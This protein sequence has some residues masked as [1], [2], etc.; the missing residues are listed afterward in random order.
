MHGS[1]HVHIADSVRAK[2]A[3][4][5]TARFADL[6]PFCPVIQALPRIPVGRLF[7]VLLAP[8]GGPCSYRPPGRLPDRPAPSHRGSTERMTG[9]ASPPPG[10]KTS[11]AP[12]RSTLCPDLD[13]AARRGVMQQGFPVSPVRDWIR[14]S[15]SCTCRG[16]VMDL[17][18]TCRIPAPVTRR[19][20]RLRCPL[21]A[22]ASQV[23]SRL[24]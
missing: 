14:R 15:R 3:V 16:L 21:V 9:C 22:A 8:G 19:I 10:W 24:T 17:S 11:T 4:R 2:L 12:R 5:I 13:A 18:S 6:R 20:T 23:P 1:V 7:A